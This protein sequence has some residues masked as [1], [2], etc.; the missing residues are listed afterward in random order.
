MVTFSSILIDGGERKMELKKNLSYNLKTLRK[1]RSKSLVEFSDEIGIAKS[2]LQ[3][4]ESGKN[5]TL[6]TVDFISEHLNISPIVLLSGEEPDDC[7]KLEQI[8]ATAD[9][10]RTSSREKQIRIRVLLNELMELLHN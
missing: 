1:L 4:M 2:T 7:K 6:D 10:Y 3:N 5:T 8:L 9:W